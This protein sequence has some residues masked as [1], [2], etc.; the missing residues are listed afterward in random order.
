MKRGVSKC[1][2]CFFFYLSVLLCVYLHVQTHRH[3]QLPRKSKIR[4][5]MLSLES[6]SRSPSSTSLPSF[7][8]YLFCSST[9]PTSPFFSR[10]QTSP[11]VLVC[12]V[13]RWLTGD[14]LQVHCCLGLEPQTRCKQP[15]TALRAPLGTPLRTYTPPVTSTVCCLLDTY[16][17]QSCQEGVARTAW[18]GNTRQYLHV[19]LFS[20]SR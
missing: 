14:V 12:A 5:R 15:S 7:L 8:V 11:A 10:T 13:A 1:C 4:K 16:M 18:Q 9:D 17:M 19:S 2:G 3:I 20:R 6:Y